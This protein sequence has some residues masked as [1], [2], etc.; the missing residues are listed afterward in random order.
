M[1]EIAGGTE[2]PA[3]ARR[4]ALSCLPNEPIGASQAD[5]A[6]IVS[7]LVTNSVVHAHVDAS[8]LLKITVARLN[9]RVRIAVADNGSETVPHLREVNADRPGGVGL[10]IIDQLCLSWGV[11]GTGAGPSEVW[12]DVPFSQ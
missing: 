11:F 2:A 6:L 12:C 10:R 1:I 7:E 4:W 8:Q 9:D 3:N 5:V